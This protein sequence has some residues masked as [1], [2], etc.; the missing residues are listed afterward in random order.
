MNDKEAKKHIQPWNELK[1]RIQQTILSSTQPTQSSSQTPLQPLPLIQSPISLPQGF[2]SKTQLYTH[3]PT[4]RN[5]Q[6]VPSHGIV[7]QIVTLDSHQAVLWKNSR[8]N[9]VLFTHVGN[10]KD[11]KAESSMA[12]VRCWVFI[13]TWNVFI[14]ANMQLEM[15]VFFDCDSVIERC[16]MQT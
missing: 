2:I 4:M 5:A 12:G 16:L 7:D 11:G 1:K 3:K 15:K 8:R 14:I 13:P 9:K 10:K 6:Y